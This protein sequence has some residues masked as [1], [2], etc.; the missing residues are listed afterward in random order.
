MK[1]MVVCVKV[2]VNH[3]FLVCFAQLACAG[4]DDTIIFYDVINAKSGKVR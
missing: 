1:S 3:S 4:D 2:R